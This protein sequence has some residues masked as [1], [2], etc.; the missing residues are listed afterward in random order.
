MVQK[1]TWYKTK[2]DIRKL[3]YLEI[4]NKYKQETRNCTTE[5]NN[6]II[7]MKKQEKLNGRILSKW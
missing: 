3:M 1:Y 4:T 5:G 6:Q 7:R 2:Y